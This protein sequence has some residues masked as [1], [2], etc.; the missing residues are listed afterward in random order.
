M[1]A[2]YMPRMR[3]NNMEIRIAKDYE[4]SYDD[5]P[6]LKVF[7]PVEEKNWFKAPPDIN[8]PFKLIAMNSIY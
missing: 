2:T 5:G 1:L 4:N 8:S 7:P 3:N 6:Q